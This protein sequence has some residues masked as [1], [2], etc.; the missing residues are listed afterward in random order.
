MTI[1]RDLCPACEAGHLRPTAKAGRRMPVRQIPDLE[2]PRDLPVPTCDACHAEILGDKDLARLGAAM[3]A[4]F[5]RALGVK[6]EVAIR[7]LGGV[8]NQRELERLIGVSAGYVSKVKNGQTEPSGPLTALL[9]LL[10]RDTRRIAE[11]RDAW[12]IR[13]VSIAQGTIQWMLGSVVFSSMSAF[14]DTAARSTAKVGK[15]FHY[16]AANEPQIESGMEPGQALC[17]QA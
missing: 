14:T 8:I 7:D 13:P 11:L 1:E 17:E 5:K 16:A 9:M 10:A 6:A 3:E 12:S 4:E 15:Q 2:I